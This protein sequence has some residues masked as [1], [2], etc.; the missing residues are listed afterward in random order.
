MA[1][2]VNKD[3]KIKNG[4]IVEGS[5]ATVGGQDVLTKK[6]ADLDYIVSLAGGG[7][8]SANVANKVV[9]RDAS[10][11]FAAGTITAALTGALDNV[12]YDEH[13]V[14]GLMM[15]NSCP[16]VPADILHPK[17]TWADKDAYDAKANQLAEAFVKNF[18]QF[19]E[20][21]NSEILEAAPKVMQ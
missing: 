20:N 12:E 16:D 7:A 15:P 13:E 1:S 8:D 2:T 21:A 6:Q 19:E 14:F 18:K 5:S 11:N 10:G 17:S 3:F 9:K 4:L